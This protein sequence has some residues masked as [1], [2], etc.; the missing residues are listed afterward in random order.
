[1][2]R[3]RA[4]SSLAHK[5]MSQLNWLDRS[6]KGDKRFNSPLICHNLQTDITSKPHRKERTE[7][8]KERESDGGEDIEL[9]SRGRE[10]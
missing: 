5:V 4:L 8:K 1:M 2:L 6:H 7:R 9:C 3:D 10:K